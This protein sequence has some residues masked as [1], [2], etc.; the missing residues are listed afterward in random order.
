MSFFVFVLLVAVMAAL[1]GSGAFAGKVPYLPLSLHQQRRLALLPLAVYA[2]TVGLD[3]LLGDGSL[4][5][6]PVLPAA[7]IFY[8]ILV[9]A[10]RRL[11]LSLGL[12]LG[13]VI[14]AALPSPLL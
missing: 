12:S 4:A 8:I 2:G 6:N 5:V 13:I 14:L 7:A 9:I 10:T 11:G 3:A 1:Y